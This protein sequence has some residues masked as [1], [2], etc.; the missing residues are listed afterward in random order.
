[1]VDKAPWHA[2]QGTVDRAQESRAGLITWI[3]PHEFRTE[4]LRAPLRPGRRTEN[5]NGDSR[6][7]PT[8]SGL[9]FDA[10]GTANAAISI[11]VPEMF[12]GSSHARPRGL[13]WRENR[14]PSIDGCR[15]CTRRTVCRQCAVG[16]SRLY[17]ESYIHRIMVVL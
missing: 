3:C 2:R 12:S 9:V 13:S 1:M 8:G 7:I 16:E 15:Y 17:H 10:S 11:L 14:E 6:R 4:A 5:C